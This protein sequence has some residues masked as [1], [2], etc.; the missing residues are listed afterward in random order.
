VLTSTGT[1]SSIFGY[2]GEQADTTGLIYLRARYMNPRLGIFLARDPWSGN[3][4][5]PFTLHGYAYVQANPINLLDPAGLCPICGQAPPPPKRYCEGHEQRSN[6]SQGAPPFGY[7]PD[8]TPIWGSM[9]RDVIKSESSKFGVPWQVVEGVLQSE[10]RFDTEL[11]DEIE[12]FTYSIDPELADIY[13]KVI[14]D[15]GTG[16]GNVHYATAKSI[17]KYYEDY[18]LLCKNMQLGIGQDALPSTIVKKLLD[19][20]FT[21]KT[22]AAYVRQLADYRFGSNGRPLMQ[23]HAI[24]AEWTIVDAVAIWHGYRYGVPRVSPGG[25]GFL[26]LEDFQNRSYSLDKLVNDVVQGKGDPSNSARQVV[27]VFEALFKITN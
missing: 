19:S 16:I 5:Q 18:Y 24:L 14:G 22:I 15:P 7:C 4:R 2:A 6:L 21:V 11:Q 9:F 23:T 26:S 12:N 3:Y 8:G 13:Y 27:P 20:N 1:A 17:S 25:Q 10:K